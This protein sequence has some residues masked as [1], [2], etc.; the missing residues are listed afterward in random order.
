MILQTNYICTYLCYDYSNYASSTYRCSEKPP[1]IFATR[2]YIYNC[3]IYH[4]FVPKDTTAFTQYYA[5]LLRQ[6]VVIE[7]MN[8]L[9]DANRDRWRSKYPDFETFYRR[10]KVDGKMVDALVALAES[11]GIKPNDQDLK[12]S[13]KD[14]EKYMKALAA[15]S[16][17]SRDSFYRI[18]NEGDPDFEKAFET[19]KAM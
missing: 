11:K 13:R 18:I 19:I 7:F 12:R 3:C 4:V 8:D 5:S 10:F 1:A 2:Y 14:L 6:G 17:V 16:I 15:G 9:C